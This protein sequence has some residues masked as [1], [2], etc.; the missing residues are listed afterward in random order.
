[1]VNSGKG[2]ENGQIRLHKRKKSLYFSGEKQWVRTWN[3]FSGR[4]S[5]IRR[6][7]GIRHGKK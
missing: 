4:L 7:E 6:R 3:M 5:Y 1:M 2:G